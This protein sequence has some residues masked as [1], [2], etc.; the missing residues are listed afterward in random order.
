MWAKRHKKQR[1]ELVVHQLQGKRTVGENE[2]SKR[3]TKEM[4]FNLS[5]EEISLYC[6]LD[7]DFPSKSKEF[8]KYTK[9]MASTDI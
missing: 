5:F 2:I 6:I 9:G 8:L 4:L 7:R 3:Y 1:E